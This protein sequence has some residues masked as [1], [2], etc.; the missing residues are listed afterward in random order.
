MVSHA[1]W[2]SQVEEAMKLATYAVHL[3]KKWVYV[4]YLHEK[5]NAEEEACDV[6]CSWPLLF[7]AAERSV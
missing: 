5:G 2:G 3:P 4:Y 6:D 7:S 1:A